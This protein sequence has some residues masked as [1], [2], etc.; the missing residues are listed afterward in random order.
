MAGTGSGIGAM[1]RMAVGFQQQCPRVAVDLIAGIGSTGVIKAVSAGRI[2]I[3]LSFRPLTQEERAMGLG[4]APYGRTPFVFAVQESNP[5]AG[6]M[7]TEIEQIYMGGR[8]RWPD[9]KRV[10]PILRPRQADPSLFLASINI[11]LKEA[12][13]KAHTIPGVYV[14]MTDGEAVEQIEKTPGSFGIGDISLLTLEKR[15]IKAL[16]VDG[17]TPALQN[18]ADGIH[19]SPGKYPYAM[20]L[21]LV[22]RRDHPAEPVKDFIAFVFSQNGKKILSESGYLPLPRIT[23]K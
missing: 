20:T 4:E 9:G 22:Y 15:K 21:S 13:T 1:R 14:G 8:E 5:T 11:R 10:R 7:M 2:D 19:I 12:Y 17:A 18:I 6:L 16:T 23:G 3:G